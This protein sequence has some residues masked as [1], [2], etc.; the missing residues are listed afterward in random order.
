VASVQVTATADSIPELTESYQF[1]IGTGNG[2][3]FFTVAAATVNVTD[4]AGTPPP[5]VAR[6]SDFSGKSGLHR[7]LGACSRQWVGNPHR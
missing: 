7:L 3:S 5:P 1:Q 4:L 2:T 6:S